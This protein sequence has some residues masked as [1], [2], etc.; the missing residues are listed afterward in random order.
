MT[1]RYVNLELQPVETLFYFPRDIQSTI[2]KL[3]CEFT[4][5][6]GTKKLLE[7]RIEERSKAEVKYEDAVAAGNTAVIGRI[8]KAC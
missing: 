7:T 2:T 8:G 5:R 4:L 1:Q 6:D 3:T